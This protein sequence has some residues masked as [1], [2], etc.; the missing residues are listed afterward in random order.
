MFA[1]MR[2]ISP[3]NGKTEL[4]KA[5]VSRKYL[6][7]VYHSVR[8]RYPAATPVLETLKTR[9]YRCFAEN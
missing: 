5:S 3:Y 7:L 6:W 4:A 2:V 1:S 8:P 9:P